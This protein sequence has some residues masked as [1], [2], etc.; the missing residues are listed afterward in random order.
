MKANEGKVDRIV[1]AIAGI[2]LFVLGFLIV[3]GTLGLILGIISI[4]LL[5][6]AALG[7]CGLYTLLK[8]DTTR[9]APEPQ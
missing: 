7:F 2:C 8:I 6:T 1:R 9:K 5:I 3:K 4:A